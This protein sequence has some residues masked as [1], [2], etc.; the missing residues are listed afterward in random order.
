M[1]NR[2]LQLLLGFLR[3]GADLDNQ[4]RTTLTVRRA[5][6]PDVDRPPSYVPVP[7]SLTR[8][9][10]PPPSSKTLK[11]AVGLP[12]ASGLSLT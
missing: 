8:C 11:D 4:V 9:G 5:S 1:R 2:L 3:A 10:L 12:V 6:T 7:V